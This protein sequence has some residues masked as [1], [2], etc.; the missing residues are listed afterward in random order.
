MCRAPTAPPP[1]LTSF[2]YHEN[3]FAS[4]QSAHLI[5]TWRSAVKIWINLKFEHNLRQ[6]SWLPWWREP[7]PSGG[8]RRSKR[9]SPHA[10]SW[11][12]CTRIGS[13][14]GTRSRWTC[15]KEEA[16]RSENSAPFNSNK[17][18]QIRSKKIDKRRIPPQ[19]VA[20]IESDPKDVKQSLLTTIDLCTI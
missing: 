20:P 7:A 17:K 5:V 13:G 19:F 11:T 9:P 6:S 2:A 10:G 1:P 12:W 8:G 15:P 3:R 4:D 14:W 16:T 18:E